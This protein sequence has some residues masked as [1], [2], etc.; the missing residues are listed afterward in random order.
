MTRKLTRSLAA[1]SG[2]S[3]AGWITALSYR[4]DMPP[5]VLTTRIGLTLPKSQALPLGL[6]FDIPDDITEDVS[7][8]TSLTAAELGRVP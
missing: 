1:R 3:L 2:E 5:Q 4:L 7:A 6:L 8:N